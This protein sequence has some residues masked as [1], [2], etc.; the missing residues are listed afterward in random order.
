MQLSTTETIPGAEIETVLGVAKGNTVQSR[1]V[2]SDIG[3]GLKNLV[4]GE[5]KGYSKL[6]TRARDEALERLE[7]D[8]VEMGA[9]A[10]V[11]VRFETSEITQGGAEILAYGTAVTLR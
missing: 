7:A 3:A 2:G 11:N 6:M 4:G 5:L 10:V 8:A 1:N 9:D